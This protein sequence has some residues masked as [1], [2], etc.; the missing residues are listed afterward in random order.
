MSPFWN[1]I[2]NG[3][4]F[5]HKLQFH[6]SPQSHMTKPFP[7]I[8][9][10]Q[11]V[12]DPQKICNVPHNNR[13]LG[14]AQSRITVKSQNTSDGLFGLIYESNNSAM[15]SNLRCFCLRTRR[16]S[17]FYFHGSRPIRV[18]VCFQ[19]KI[20]TS[21]CIGSTPNKCDCSACRPDRNESV[22]RS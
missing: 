2:Q 22:G 16:V 19:L 10:E 6:E 20:T 7:T 3:V 8:N 21:Q 1:G 9:P 14:S 15:V 11:N 4:S 12:L 5:P 13:V 18:G 17:N